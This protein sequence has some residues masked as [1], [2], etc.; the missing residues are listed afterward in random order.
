MSIFRLI[1]HAECVTC[2]PLPGTVRRLRSRL[3]HSTQLVSCCCEISGVSRPASRRN[4][5]RA[6]RSCSGELPIPSVIRA[7][8]PVRQRVPTRRSLPSGAYT[9]FVCPLIERNGFFRYKLPSRMP[10]TSVSPSAAVTKFSNNSS[11]TTRETSTLSV[12]PPVLRIRTFDREISRLEQQLFSRA[13]PMPYAVVARIPFGQPGHE[14]YGSSSR[15]GRF[16]HGAVFL[17]NRSAANACY[18]R[19]HKLRIVVVAPALK[20]WR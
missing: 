14:R 12:T 15:R 9:A 17:G 16:L 20:V 8:P 7:T 19:H 5:P 18:M 10:D 3:G 13:G 2:T 1:F 4:R 6:V 11:M